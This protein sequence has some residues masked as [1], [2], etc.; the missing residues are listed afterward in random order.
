MSVWHWDRPSSIQQEVFNQLGLD[1]ADPMTSPWYPTP[2]SCRTAASIWS[3]VY[4]LVSNLLTS[5]SWAP[6]IYKK[7]KFLINIDLHRSGAWHS[8][9]N[10]HGMRNFSHG[11][12]TEECLS[13][14]LGRYAMEMHTRRA[15]WQSKKEFIST[16]SSGHRAIFI[17]LTKW[18]HRPACTEDKCWTDKTRSNTSRIIKLFSWTNPGRKAQQRELC[19]TYQRHKKKR[20]VRVQ[21]RSGSAARSLPSSS[22]DLLHS[23]AQPGNRVR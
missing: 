4:R 6:H 16:E 7:K 8:K 11:C 23:T 19:L 13:W 3:M 1:S 17:L 14:E 21:A 20:Q 22:S 12:D 18:T 15:L 5:S 10:N 2:S 9:G